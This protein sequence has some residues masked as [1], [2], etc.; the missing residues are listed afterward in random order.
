MLISFLGVDLFDYVLIPFVVAVALNAVAFQITRFYEGF[1]P[2]LSWLVAPLKRRNI[3]RSKELYGPLFSKRLEYL[4]LYREERKLAKAE[5]AA[6]PGPGALAPVGTPK[7]KDVRKQ[8]GDLKREIQALHE[9]IE[10]KG[11]SMLNF[12]LLA[13]VAAIESIVVIFFI[14]VALRGEPWR[15]WA[16]VGCGESFY[17]PE[18][19]EAE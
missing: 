17:F 16:L 19:A 4:K 10:A 1:V 3:A 12:S 13:Y 5:A 2:P 14:P 8:L 11:G 15:V 6:P 9:K 7:A 18:E